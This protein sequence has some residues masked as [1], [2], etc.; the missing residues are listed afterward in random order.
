[1]VQDEKLLK[2]K[3]NPKFTRS[4]VDIEDRESNLANRSSG[5]EKSMRTQLERTM[6]SRN[7]HTLTRTT[8]I[9]TVRS[10]AKAG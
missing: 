7:L 9:Q 6:M 5:S 3:A 4:S 10:L 2:N 8:T 1:M